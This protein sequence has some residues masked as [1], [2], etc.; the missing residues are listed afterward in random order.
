MRSKKSKLENFMISSHDNNFISIIDSSSHPAQMRIEST[1]NSIK[2]LTSNLKHKKQS[3]F[4]EKRNII[5]KEELEDKDKILDYI[6]KTTAKYQSNENNKHSQLQSFF[7]KTERD[8]YEKELFALMLKEDL[9][10]ASNDDLMNN[11]Y[12]QIGND[13]KPTTQL[14]LRGYV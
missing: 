5:F 12:F 1:Q 11:D 9:K 14:P 4:E 13:K 8:G 2:Y 6:E 7:T 3:D 10:K